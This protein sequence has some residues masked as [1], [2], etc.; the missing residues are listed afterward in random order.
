MDSDNILLK[1]LASGDKQSFEVLFNRYYVR[2]CVYA[3]KF[4]Y[5]KDVSEQVV[6]DVFHKLWQKRKSLSVHT[7]LKSYLFTS[8]HHASIDFLRKSKENKQ[9]TQLDAY[10]PGTY[11]FAVDENCLSSLIEKELAEEIENA[12]TELPTDCRKIFLLSREKNSTYKEIAEELEISV[13]TVETQMGRALKKL[14]EK[15][16]KHLSILLFFI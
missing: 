7:S 14:R 12:I 8:V 6:L 15:L 10:E 11:D 1:R 5:Q 2:L 9:S 3:Q 4:L 16:S 13:K